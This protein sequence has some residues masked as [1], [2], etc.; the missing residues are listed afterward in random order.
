PNQPT[1]NTSV[2]L[3]RVFP[4]LSFAAPIAMKQAPGEPNNWYVVEQRGTI[5]RFSTTNPVKTQW[6]DLQNIVNESS[7]EAGLLGMAFHPNYATNARVF[8]SY[9]GDGANPFQ[10][11][12]SEFH[13]NG[14]TLDT[15]SERIF[16]RLDQPFDNH[17][18]GN[19]LFG[20]DGNLYIGFGDGGSGG[21]P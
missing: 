2:S 9:T 12:I 11:H 4:T 17:N 10:S 13:V 14:G 18:G 20:P 1:T 6:A 3:T 5:Q 16:L 19:I 21:D 7:S 15:T 8:L